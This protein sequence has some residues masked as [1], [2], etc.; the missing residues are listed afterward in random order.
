M[1]I[2]MAS[3]VILSGFCI[4]T[5]VAGVVIMLRME[6]IASLRRY[7]LEIIGL[8]FLAPFVLLLR[9]FDL[10]SADAATSIAGA[11]VGYFFRAYTPSYEEPQP[12]ELNLRQD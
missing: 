7:S 9:F 12:L 11:M 3:Q 1:D 5:I 8:T 6:R 2:K 4:I 10:I